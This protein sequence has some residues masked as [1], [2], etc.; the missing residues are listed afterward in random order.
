MHS[1]RF[2]NHS[3]LPAIRALPG[4]AGIAENPDLCVM[5]VRAD[6]MIWAWDCHPSTK[7]GTRGFDRG[8][9][10]ALIEGILERKCTETKLSSGVL[11]VFCPS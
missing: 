1:E 5:R 3:I 2:L 9:K 11:P 6:G 10:R 7:G 8:S 4:L